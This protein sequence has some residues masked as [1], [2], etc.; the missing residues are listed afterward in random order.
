MRPLSER[1]Q[2]HSPLRD[3]AGMLRSIGYA[4]AAAGRDPSSK[5]QPEALRQWTEAMSKSFLDA[6][7]R[8]IVGCASYPSDPT[9]ADQLLTLFLLEKAFYEITYE[10]ANRPDWVEIPLTGVLELMRKRTASN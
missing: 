10:L 5:Y 7:R 2:K 6:Y 3:V 1:R 9:V 4:A 8:T